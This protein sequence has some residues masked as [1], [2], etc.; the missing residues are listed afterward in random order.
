[1]REEYRGCVI[2]SIGRDLLEGAVWVP[3]CTI[4]FKNYA[5]RTKVE[6]FFSDHTCGT[7]ERAIAA[8]AA[9]AKQTIDSRLHER[10]KQVAGGS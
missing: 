10:A 5:G 2:E 4:E 1:M 8:G 7:E 9:N 3:V 6:T